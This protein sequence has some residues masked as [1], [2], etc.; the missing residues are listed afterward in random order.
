MKFIYM[1]SINYADFCVICFV[2]I[3]TI[4]TFKSELKYGVVESCKQFK[5]I[6]TG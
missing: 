5:D 6:I 2:I 1:K 4:W 3:F